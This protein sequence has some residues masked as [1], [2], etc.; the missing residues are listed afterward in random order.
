MMGFDLCL[1]DAKPP[2][3]DNVSVMCKVSKV[4]MVTAIINVH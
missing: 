2:Q 1:E 3:D 4:E